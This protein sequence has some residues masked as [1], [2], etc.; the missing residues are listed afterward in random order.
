MIGLGYHWFRGRACPKSIW[1]CFFFPTLLYFAFSFSY[2][3]IDS[4]FSPFCVALHVL[5]LT[6]IPFLHYYYSVNTSGQ[7]QSCRDVRISLSGR[8]SW[9]GLL[10]QGNGPRT[11]TKEQ[12]DSYWE[13]YIAL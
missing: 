6:H 13:L 4:P 10:D 3:S 12:E 2:G 7:E 11:K 1:K 8:P 9:A 5:G